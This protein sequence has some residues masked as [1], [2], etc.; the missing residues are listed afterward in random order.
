MTL[1]EI[2]GI[3]KSMQG[4]MPESSRALLADKFIKLFGKHLTNRTDGAM[5]KAWVEKGGVSQ[6]I[7]E[8]DLNAGKPWVDHEIAV[9][10][11][12]LAEFINRWMNIDKFRRSADSDFEPITPDM[13]AI[14]SLMVDELRALS[15]EREQDASDDRSD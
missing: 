6:F 10:D 9:D 8:C 3:I 13:N 5:L 7:H 14:R 4:K 12:E 11:S 15:L 2:A 1:S